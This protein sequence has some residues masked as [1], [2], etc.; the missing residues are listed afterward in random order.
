MKFIWLGLILEILILAL[1]KPLIS[2]FSGVGVIAIQLHMIFTMITFMSYKFKEKYIFFLAFLSRVAFMFW[3]LYARNIFFLPNSGSD[4]ESF[5]RQAIY[6]SENINLL[7]VV[8]GEVYSKALGIIFKLIGPQRIMGQ[9]INVLLGL[10]I[11]FI[12]YKLLLMIDV[13]KRI[14]KMILL[15]ASFFPN[16][17]IMSAILLREIIPTFFVALSL[18]H[19]V[20]WVKFQKLSNAMLAVIILGIASTFHSGIIGG[21]LGYFF[22]FLFYNRSQNNL[23]FSLKT[24]VSFVFIG[25]IIALSFTYFADTLFGKFRNVEEISDIY[26]K[27]NQRLGGSTYLTTITINNPLQLVIFGPVKSFYF[28]TSPLPINWRGFMDV[29]TFLT[30]SMLYLITIIYVIKNKKFFGENR[31][32]IICI[33]WVIIGAAFIFGIGVGNA[34]TAV[35]HRQKLVALFLVLLGMVMDSK[36][37]YINKLK[38]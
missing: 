1:I 33:I 19:F 22:G 23:K 37:K 17:L 7:F 34:G 6:F 29:F 30:D 20:K 3:D 27:A 5:Y 18:Y 26:N 36:K 15:I 31:A 25:A 9:Y 10:S 38:I 12:V 13:D 21:S 2:D 24:I 28:L 14:A 35:R 32:L 16:S 11:V 8:E 4:T